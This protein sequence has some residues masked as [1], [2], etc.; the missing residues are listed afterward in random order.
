M[1]AH[2]E[3]TPPMSRTET[4][5]DF[6]ARSRVEDLPPEVIGMGKRCLL[7][8][9]GVALAGS[10]EPAS[11]LVVGFIGEMG[12]EKQASVLGTGIKTSVVNAA[13]ALGTMAHVLDYDDA[14]SMVRSHV[15]APLVAALLPVAEYR[16]MTGRAFLTAL[17]TGFEVSTRVGRALGREYYEAGWHATAILGRFGAAAGVGKLLGLDRSRLSCAF[18]LA[19]TQ[20]AGLRDAFGTMTKPFH[21]GKAASDGVLAAMLAA[22]GFTAPK[23]ILDDG[24]GFARLFTSS[25]KGGLICA[26]LG[27]VYDIMTNSFKPYAAC[28]LVHPVVDGLIRLRSAH[29]IDAGE[30]AEI[31]IEAAPLNL[32]VTGNAR[33]KNGLEGKFSLPMAAAVAVLYGRAG[34]ALFTDEMA[35]D[36][37]VTALMAKVTAAPNAAFAET[38]AHITVIGKDGRIREVRVTAAKGDPANPLTVAEIEEKF[39]ELAGSVLPPERIPEIAGRVRHLEDEED[40]SALVGLCHG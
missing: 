6:I 20:A 24:T 3:K 1:A 8:W 34:N 35:A 18:G 4:V 33:P 5:A 19:A 13:L 25:Y 9:L 15:S 21:A 32:A 36:P 12:G 28:L 39:A 30:I 17:I 14:H 31:R 26:D 22:S 11:R 16:R 38:E 37:D 7:D 40:M 10:K 27:V 2:E 29:D 23:D